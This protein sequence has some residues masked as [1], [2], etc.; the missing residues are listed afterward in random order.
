M[1]QTLY[2]TVENKKG[3]LSLALKQNEEVKSSR[4]RILKN[5]TKFLKGMRK[6]DSKGKEKT[7]S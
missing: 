1:V 7:C 5:V 6:Y 4:L 2:Q 3:Q